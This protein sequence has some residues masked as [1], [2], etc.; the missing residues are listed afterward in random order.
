[1]LKGFLVARLKE[2]S[3]WAGLVGLATSL[4]LALSPEQKELIILIGSSLAALVFTLFKDPASPLVEPPK[5][6]PLVRK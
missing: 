6:V 4:G 2:R 1:M 5:P 3:T